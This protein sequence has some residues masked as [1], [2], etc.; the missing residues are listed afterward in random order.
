MQSGCVLMTGIKAQ[1]K[2]AIGFSVR[3]IDAERGS[4]LPDGIVSVVI[5]VKHIGQPAV[6]IGRAGHFVA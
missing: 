6:R 1:T 5:A 3:G 2:I 4:R